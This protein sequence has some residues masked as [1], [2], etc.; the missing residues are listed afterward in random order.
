MKHSKDYD[1]EKYRFSQDAFCEQRPGYLG[2]V[3][4]I[5][6]SH[7]FSF[8]VMGGSLF[9]FIESKSFE[10]SVAE[11]GTFFLLRIFKRGRDSLRSVFMGKE[12]AKRMLAMMEDFIFSEPSGHFARSVRD[13]ESVLLLQLGSNAHGSFLMISELLHGR[14]KGFII[15]PEGKSGSGWRGFC[16]HLRKAIAPEALAINLPPKPLP[17]S[18]IKNSKS[19]AA[20]VVQG[21]RGEPKTHRQVAV[22]NAL[23]Q[24]TCDVVNP[25]HLMLDSRKSNLPNLGAQTQD[26][27][28]RSLGKENALFGAVFSNDTED[29]VLLKL[30]IRLVRGPHG[31]WR[32][33]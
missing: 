17:G 33:S 25:P 24:D 27:R 4:R 9:F 20:A 15:V 11:G 16:L 19:F 30:Y 23:N 13:G 31:K 18:N 6:L 7:F 21:R 14:R 3:T 12:S 28:E 10:F 29:G 1:L 5:L 32:I 22:E 2:L 8:F 26:S